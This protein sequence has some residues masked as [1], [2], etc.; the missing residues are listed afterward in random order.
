MT[1][2]NADEGASLARRRQALA[3]APQ[4][5]VMRSRRSKPAIA[6]A[7]LWPHISAVGRKEL[8]TAG[9]SG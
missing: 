9:L 1:S 5:R 8:H 2:L 7:A 4:G 6:S 3:M